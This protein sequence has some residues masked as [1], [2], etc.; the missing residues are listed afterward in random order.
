MK[1]ERNIFEKTRPAKIV[2]E[3]ATVQQRFTAVVQVTNDIYD[4]SSKKEKTMRL[5]MVNFVAQ[6]S[7]FYVPN[8]FADYTFA[9]LR[10]PIP[11]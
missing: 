9:F 7:H 6:P 10:I 2:L 11:L 1:K 5:L 8:S 3:N 4:T